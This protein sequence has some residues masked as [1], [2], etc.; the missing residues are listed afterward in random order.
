[1]YGS[2]VLGRRQVADLSQRRLVAAQWRAAVFLCQLST[3]WAAAVR[4]W[5]AL[6]GELSPEAG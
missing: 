6:T 2:Q 4:A 3:R 5:R 1:M